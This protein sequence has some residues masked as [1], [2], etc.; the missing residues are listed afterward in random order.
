MAQN[1][2]RPLLALFI[3]SCVAAL[4]QAAPPAENNNEGVPTAPVSTVENNAPPPQTG[5][6]RSTTAPQ[7]SRPNME[8]Q[9][10]E[11]ISED[12]S[13]AFPTDI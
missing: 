1:R 2:G 6:D 11:E 13:V 10:S 5:A 8:F 4:T 12:F 9:P 7:T 3:L